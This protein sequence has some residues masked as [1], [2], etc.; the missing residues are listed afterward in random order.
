MGLMMQMS[1]LS[2]GD[3]IAGR[4]SVKTITGSRKA[5]LLLVV[6]PS[7]VKTNQ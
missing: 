6:G 1:G 4:M 5:R 7:V 3:L 2:V